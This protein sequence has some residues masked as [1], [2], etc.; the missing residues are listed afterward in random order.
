MAV[1]LF[2]NLLHVAPDAM[3]DSLD[4][5]VILF[6]LFPWLHHRLELLPGFPWNANIT[7][8]PDTKSSRL[9]PLVIDRQRG[10]DHASHPLEAAWP[11]HRLDSN[12]V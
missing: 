7:D 9:R 1:V 5:E 4:H 2:L 3:V 12:L 8:A 6:D 11:R 10:N